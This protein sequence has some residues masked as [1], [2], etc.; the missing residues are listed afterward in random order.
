[1][2]MG[3]GIGKWKSGTDTMFSVRSER[4]WPHYFAFYIETNKRHTFLGQKRHSKTSSTKMQ[5]K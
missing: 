1:M 4:L 3:D 5:K 2:E